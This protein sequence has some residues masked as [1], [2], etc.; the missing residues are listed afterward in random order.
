MS[1]LGPASPSLFQS[2]PLTEARGDRKPTAEL[3]Y[4]ICFNPL[5]SPKQGETYAEADFDTPPMRFQSAPLTEAR[6]DLFADCQPHKTLGV[7]IRS[8]HRSKGRLNAFP[9]TP[10]GFH[11]SIR[12]PHRSKGRLHGWSQ[13]GAGR[14]VSIRSPH[15]SKGRHV[16]AQVRCRTLEFQ[17]APLTEAR[18]DPTAR[19]PSPP[20]CCFNPLPSPKQGETH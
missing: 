2:A 10:A 1:S 7:S 19:P 15:R 3:Q 20:R 9:N 8:P 17:S 18:G 14:V 12:S 5:P 6:G 16:Q 13:I 11:V 4:P